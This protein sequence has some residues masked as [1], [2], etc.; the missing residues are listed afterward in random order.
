MA[1]LPAPLGAPFQKDLEKFCRVAPP[2]TL[3]ELKELKV[4]LESKGTLDT[5]KAKCKDKS[6]KPTGVFSAS[7]ANA[8]GDHTGSSMF[9]AWFRDNC[10]IAYG[11]YLTDPDGPGADDAVA[12]I[13]AIAKFLL[14]TQA[15]KMEMVINGMKDVKG[16][17]PTWMDRPHIRFIGETGLEDPKW[18][19]HKQNDALGYFLW[20][21]CQLAWG[22]KLPFDGEHLKL[23]GQLFDYLR[24]IESWQDLDGGHWEEH[25]AV[26]SSS[27]GPPLAAVRLFKKV[28]ERDGLLAPCKS[29]TLDLLDTKLT[30]ALKANVPNEITVPA[31]LH[32]DADSACIFLCYPLE[33]VDDEVGVQIVDRLKKVMGHI[34]MCRYRKDSYWCR[35]Y[36]DRVGDDPTKHFTDEE[37][38][39]RDAMLKDGE[40]AQWC[41]FDP[42]VSCY[43]GKLY[44]KTR[45]PE[46]LKMQMLFL[47]RALA[48]ITGDDCPYGGWH[49][50][51][52]YYLE[53]DKWV[54]NDDTPLVWTQID[55][56][57]ALYE[58][59]K[60]LAPARKRPAA[61]TPRGKVTKKPAKR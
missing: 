32:R 59:E 33:V 28:I 37:L 45:D 48:A 54:P 6:G 24:A 9:G 21:R 35:D 58:M 51:E 3:D 26:H 47:S 31:E 57:M 50:A 25:S 13:S 56:K 46:H 39:A 1:D 20:C 5:N 4:L 29:D 7:A 60:S 49:C 41:L 18:Y 10:I 34:G 12:C 8:K 40:E 22:N 55:L 36:K 15:H 14:T 2:L 17:E 52:A 53:K 11:L 23:M 19:N 42:M 61:A 27:I 38:K 43:H 44:Q 16:A 30:E